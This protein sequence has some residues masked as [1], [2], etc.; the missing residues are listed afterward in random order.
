MKRRSPVTFSV[1]S[2]APWS[3]D[4]V[5]IFVKTEIEH[6]YYAGEISGIESWI[7]ANYKPVE[8]AVNVSGYKLMQKRRVLEGM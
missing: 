2:N 6:G 1:F 7:E 5:K 3:D 8:P 4:M